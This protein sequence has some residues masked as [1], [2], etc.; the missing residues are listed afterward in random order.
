MKMIK[1]KFH[2]VIEFSEKLQFRSLIR[3]A[4]F[5]EKYGFFN[6]TYS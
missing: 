2:E 6:F 3:T 4:K 5:N 1:K